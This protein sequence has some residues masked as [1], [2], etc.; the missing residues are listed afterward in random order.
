MSSICEKLQ[1]PLVAHNALGDCEGLLG[2][3]KSQNFLGDLLD[4]K[5]VDIFLLL[6]VTQK[7]LAG[8]MKIEK[9]RK[10]YFKWNNQNYLK[11][12]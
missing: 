5:V 12:L 6:P 4:R 7:V 11:F 2:V 3:L 1:I 8:Q 9:D 10:H